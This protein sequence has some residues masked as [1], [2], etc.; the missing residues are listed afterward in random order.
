[1][2]LDSSAILAIL[3]REPDWESLLVALEGAESVSCGAPTLA[4]AGIVLGH[5]HGFASGKLHRFVQE[6]GVTVVP[7]GVEHWVEAERAYERFGKGRHG[8]DLNFGDCLAYAVS[9][10]AE[11][12]LLFV[13]DDFSKTDIAVAEH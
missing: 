8:A 12:P 7:F 1:M 5:R 6:F 10:L 4:E 11:Q 13:G 9:K 3:F 2:I